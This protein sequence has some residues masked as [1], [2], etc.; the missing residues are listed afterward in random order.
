MRDEKTN[1]AKQKTKKTT[2][3][4]VCW[5]SRRVRPVLRGMLGPALP[6]T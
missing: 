6:P 4:L 5:L 1:K 2:G 3:D